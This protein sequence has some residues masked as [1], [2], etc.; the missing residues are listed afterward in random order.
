MNLF[1]SQ[2]NSAFRQIK[3]INLF[4]EQLRKEYEDDR[5]LLLCDN[6][7]W[8]TTENLKKPDNIVLA[9]LPPYTPEMN[10]IEQIWKEL[11]KRGFKNECF[12][13]LDKV[14]E[15]LCEVICALTNETI[16]HITRRKWLKKLPPSTC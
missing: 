6:A 1:L 16:V 11:R 8:H 4:L 12:E 10:P 2:N 9:Y 5:I 14:E 7:G 3:C 13:S 15:R